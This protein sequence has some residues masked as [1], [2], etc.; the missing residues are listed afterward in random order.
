MQQRFQRRHGLSAAFG[1]LCEREFF[2]LEH[3]HGRA[4]TGGQRCERGGDLGLGLVPRVG[5]RS[6]VGDVRQLRGGFCFDSGAALPCTQRVYGAGLGDRRDPWFDWAA[7]F[8]GV[9]HTMEAEQCLLDDVFDRARVAVVPA[10][11]DAREHRRFFQERGVGL[12]ITGLCRSEQALPAGR[13][14]FVHVIGLHERPNSPEDSRDHHE[15]RRFVNG[16]CFEVC[17]SRRRRPHTR[18][19]AED[20]WFVARDHVSVT[21]RNFWA[22]AGELLFETKAKGA[23]LMNSA[24]SRLLAVFALCGALFSASAASAREAEVYTGTFSSLAVGGYDTVAYFKAGRP[25]AGNDQFS[26]QYKGATWRFASKENLDAFVAKPMAYAPQYGGYCA[27]AVA[28]GYT[29]SGDPQVWKIV[30]G[31]LYLNY[32]RSVQAKWEKDIPG[33]IAKGDRNWPGVLN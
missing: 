23:F 16:A 8:V 20:T 1:R 27:W 13:W 6:G 31:K 3:A 32:D 33:F 14:R 9:A 19:F 11:D 7:G 10:R 17:R 2:D 28:Q 4:L 25:A 22:G 12:P 5:A 24:V 30:G 15:S 26:T 21:P 18:I 29:A